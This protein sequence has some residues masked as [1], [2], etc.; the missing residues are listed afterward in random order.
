MIC[1][2]MRD[3]LIFEQVIHGDLSARNVLLDEQRNAKVSD[4]GMSLKLYQYEEYAHPGQS[5]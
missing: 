3:Y 5:V 2:F 1:I 4:F